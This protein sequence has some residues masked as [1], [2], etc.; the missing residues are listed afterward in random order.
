VPVELKG[1]PAEDK[2]FIALRYP[3]LFEA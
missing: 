2:A 3:E 1:L